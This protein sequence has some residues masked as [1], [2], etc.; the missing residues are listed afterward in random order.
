MANLIDN[1]YFINEI[2]LPVDEI[3]SELT[4]YITRYEKEILIKILGYDLY[5]SFTDALDGYGVLA[6]KWQYL[7]D[8]LEYLVS[9]V[10]YNW[11]GLINAEKESLISY[12]VFYQFSC[13]SSTYN[14]SVGGQIIKGENSIM[15]DNRRKQ[16]YA[17]NRMV[18]L[19]E[20]LDAFIEYMNGE[21]STNYPNYVTPVIRKI[22]I[23]NV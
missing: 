4:S 20:S 2:S 21:D 17:Y 16:V 19:I 13:H 7:R 5:K 10:Y 11:S 1:T 22:N 9:G 18:E 23:F 12:Y 15:I 3:S 6:D 14:S 8:G